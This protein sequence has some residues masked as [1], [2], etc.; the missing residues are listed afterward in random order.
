MAF[1]TQVKPKS[2]NEALKDESWIAVMHEELNQFTRNDVWTL[3]PRSDKM[4]IIRT[5]WVFR[6]KLDESG[7]ITRNKAILVAKWYNQEKGID[8]DETFAPVA[9]LEVVRLLLGFACMSGFK[10]FQMDVKSAFLNGIINEEVYVSQ[11]PGFEDHLLPNH[12][13]KLKKALYGLKQAPR[14]WYERLRN[15]LLSHRYE[16][17]KINK[18][19]FIK[20]SNSAIIL[21]QIY[22]DYIIF[23]VT[24]DSLCKEFVAA[25]QGEFEM[26]MM[27]EVSFFL[28]L[29]VKQTKDDT[30][31]C[32]SKYCKEILKKFEMEKCKVATTSMSTRCYMGADEAGTAVDQTK[33]RGLICSLLYLTT[34]RPDIMFVGLSL[35]KISV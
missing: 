29:Q 2:I 35:C 25:M 17:R 24:N 27:G 33:Y 1:A 28:G 34:S 21:V 7:A 22:V 4:N 20:N 31:L 13:Y 15:F 8:Y 19:L 30:F 32:Q 23:G 3:V 10:L 16:R 18:T 5:K 11:P 9:K 12:V 26:S 14:Q 6:N